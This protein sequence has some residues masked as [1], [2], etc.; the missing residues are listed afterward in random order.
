VKDD[1]GSYVF[2]IDFIGSVEDENVRSAL[3]SV[4]EDCNFVKVLGAYQ[5]AK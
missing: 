3:S 1:F 4:R 5:A 2:Y